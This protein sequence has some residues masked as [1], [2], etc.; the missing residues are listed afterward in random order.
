M[1]ATAIALAIIALVVLGGCVAPGKVWDRG[2]M[3]CSTRN[4][5]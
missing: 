3:R 1:R 2:M 4:L 5:S